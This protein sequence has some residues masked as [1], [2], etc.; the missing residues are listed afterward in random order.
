[1][2]LAVE[3]ADGRLCLSV[4]DDGIGGADPARGSGLIGLRDRVEAIAGSIVLD[5]PPGAGTA[6][7]VSLPLD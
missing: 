7:L 3:Q 1:V 6:A 2:R 5:S 4:R